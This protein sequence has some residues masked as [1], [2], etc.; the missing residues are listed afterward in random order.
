M[1]HNWFKHLEKFQII[2]SAMAVTMQETSNVLTKSFDE[3]RI[4]FEALRKYAE[5]HV[6]KE[7]S[8]QFYMANPGGIR[9]VDIAGTP[10]IDA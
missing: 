7:E 3:L 6:N 8:E 4:S 5:D 9:R 1:F 10:Q 2:L